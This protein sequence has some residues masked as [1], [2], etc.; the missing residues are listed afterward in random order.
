MPYITQERLRELFD[1]SDG[2]FVRKINA[3]TRGKVGDI[4][5][6][7]NQHTGYLAVKV[8]GK[9][10][11]F[12]RTVWIWHH[13][14]IT[15]GLQIDHRNGNR[16]DN[17][18]ENLRLVTP[19]ENQQ[20]RGLHKMN[21]SG[22]IGVTWNKKYK[23]WHAKIKFNYK[24]IHLGNFEN[25]TDAANAYLEAKKELHTAQPKPRFL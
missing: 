15:D 1:Y 18:L 5:K 19:R 23:K 17:R 24:T 8:D 16:T 12:H 2:Y 20:N 4:V 14:D 9:K 25:K 10:H 11:L 22:F 6:G 21:T 7:T 3:G 13:G